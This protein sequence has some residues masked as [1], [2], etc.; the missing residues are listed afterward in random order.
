MIDKI[1]LVNLANA[2]KDLVNFEELLSKKQDEFETLNKAL[3]ESIEVKKKTQEELKETLRIEA[4]EEFKETN[5]KKL[6][7]GIGIRILSKLI[8]SE[9]DAMNWANENMPVALKTV[10]DK[11]QFETFAKSSDLDFVEKEEKTSVTFPKEI[12]I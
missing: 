5:Q 12:I 4:E 8:Y 11:K 9:S 3:I 7:G 2:Q 1:K 6:L 10:L